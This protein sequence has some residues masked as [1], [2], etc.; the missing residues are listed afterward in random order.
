[1]AHFWSWS[2]RYQNHQKVGIQ[3]S[4]F[5]RFLRLTKKFPG[6][7]NSAKTANLEFQ[8]NAIFVTDQN[9][10]VNDKIGQNLKLRISEN[11]TFGRLPKNFH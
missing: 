4:R 1:M 7:A 11:G 5:S 6:V 10:S 2:K 9:I 3:Y 8:E